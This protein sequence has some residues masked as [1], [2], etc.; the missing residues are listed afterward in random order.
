M[1]FIQSH[2]FKFPVLSD[3]FPVLFSIRSHRFGFPVLSDGFPVLCANLSV[4]IL[5]D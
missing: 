2:K 3:G 1:Q 4:S 5:L